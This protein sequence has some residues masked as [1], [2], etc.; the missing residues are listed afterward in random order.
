VA[1]FGGTAAVGLVLAAAAGSA[2]ASLVLPVATALLGIAFVFLSAPDP[3]FAFGF[4][5]ALGLVPLA[6]GVAGLGALR[7]SAVRWGVVL[8]VLLLAARWARVGSTARWAADW[9]DFPEPPVARTAVHRTTSGLAIE[10]PVV[11]DQCW[12]APLPCAPAFD[13]GLHLDG[14]MFRSG[15]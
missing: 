6:F 10:V 3:R 12:G 5:H 4:L 2:P 8:L 11:G 1:L 15:P 9:L 7:R 13:A 14:G